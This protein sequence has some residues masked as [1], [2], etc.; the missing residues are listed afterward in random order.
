MQDAQPEPSEEELIER[1]RQKH[2]DPSAAKEAF[3]IFYCRHRNFLYRC[4]RRAEKAL[5]GFS[6]GS[7]DLVQEVFAVV[8]RSGMKSFDMPSGLAQEDAIA[9]TRGWLN[10]VAANLVKDRLKSRKHVLPLDPVENESLFVQENEDDIGTPQ[11][12]LISVLPQCL[13]ERDVE[14]VR[15]KIHYFNPD[16]GESQPPAEILNA[17]C[18]KWNITPAVLRKAY[19]RAIQTIRQALFQSLT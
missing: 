15:F 3:S 13:S 9:R 12:H 1:M 16:T 11:L 10:S 7:E 2:E 6:V 17:F 18:E 14:I 5:V 8:W 4:L 19:A